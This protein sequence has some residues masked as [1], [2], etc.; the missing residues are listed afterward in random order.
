MSRHGWVGVIGLDFTV[1]MALIGGSCLIELLEPGAGLV[2]PPPQ[3]GEQGHG[4]VHCVGRGA[5]V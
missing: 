3:L 2:D 5:G 1:D 4:V